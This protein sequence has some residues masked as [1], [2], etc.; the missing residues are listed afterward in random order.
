MAT[1]IFH[2]RRDAGRQLGARL[3]PFAAEHPVVIGL[4]RGGV[5][6]AFEV[7]QALGAPLDVL[8]VRKI[9]APGNP[10]FGMGAI[11][12]GGVRVFNDFVLRSLQ[13]SPEEIERATQRAEHELE[14][15]LRRYR[16]ERAPLDVA[17]KTVILVDDGLATGGTARAALR[18]LRARDPGRLVLAVPVGARETIDMLAPECDGVVCV[19]TPESVGAVGYWYENFEQTTDAEVNALLAQA[20]RRP[21]ARPSRPRPC[22]QPH[23]TRRRA[24]R[25]GSRSREVGSSSATSPSPERATGLVVF[26]HG[27]GIEPPQPAQPR[28][29]R[30][31]EPRRLATLLIDLLTP[32]EERER[33]N[34][35]DIVLLAERLGAATRWVREQPSTATLALGY[36]GASTGAGAALWAAADL[37]AGV[38][39]VVSRGGRPDLAAP[40]AR[41]RARADA[42][43]RRRPRPCRD[44]AQ[45]RGRSHQLRC[46]ATL[47]IVPGATHLFEEPGTLE[48]VARL[49][50]A[51]FTRHLAGVP[52]PVG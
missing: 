34:V 17:G 13:V 4:T 30:R 48:Q 28:G 36:F 33:S 3:Q 11:A 22:G 21:A 23:R 7:A 26:A 16:G 31:A 12:E 35:F 27:S 49:A 15:R 47:E 41:R 37:G 8:V 50:V 18:A 40:R 2:D 46:D 45:P 39:A 20:A 9:G 32:A 5:P 38:Q 19:L 6:V 43:H 42:A 51:W 14:E 52:S 29:R 24:S 25:C 10:E 44:R 1:R